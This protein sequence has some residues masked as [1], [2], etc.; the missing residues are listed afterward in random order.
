MFLVLTYANVMIKFPLDRFAEVSGGAIE[1]NGQG[2]S[3]DDNLIFLLFK[4]LPLR[5]LE[6]TSVSDIGKGSDITRI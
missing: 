3:R 2:R 6:K 5:Y 4:I 1:P